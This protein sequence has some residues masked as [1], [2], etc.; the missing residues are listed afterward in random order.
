MKKY[1]V[2]FIMF[3]MLTVLSFAGDL[4]INKTD[5]N[6]VTVPLDE[7][8]SITFSSGGE[9]DELTLLCEW[10][11]GSFSSAAQADTSTDPYHYDVRLKMAQIWDD[12]E[13][14]YWLYVEQAYAESQSSPYRQR[15][16][17]VFEGEKGQLMDEIY[18]FSNA[19][20]YVGSWATPEDFDALTEDD[21]QLKPEC[22]LYF[23]RVDE[24]SFY[25]STQGT[26][27]T[28]SIPGVAYITSEST[29][30]AEYL[31]SWDLGYNSS[32]VIVMGPYSPYLFDKIE[33]FPL[34]KN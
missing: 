1:S 13:G 3:I 14:G 4:I 33:D 16:Y 10:M 19:G 9:S 31:T 32:G 24:S 30:T 6:D 11:T 23:D 29:I 17:R 25:G 34:H 22:G 28:A 2:L 21:L 15:I 18:T 20:S 27:C 12:R 7:I 8:E 26:G 5:G